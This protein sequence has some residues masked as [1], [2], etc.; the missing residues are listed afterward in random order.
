[1]HLSTIGSQG[2]L[3]RE[4]QMQRQEKLPVAFNSDR[5]LISD[6]TKFNKLQRVEAMRKRQQ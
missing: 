4:Q 2:R 3:A 1:M 5:R 6:F